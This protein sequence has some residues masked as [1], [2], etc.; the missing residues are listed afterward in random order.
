MSANI[1]NAQIQKENPAEKLQ[2]RKTA[3]ENK[4]N[5]KQDETLKKI[6]AK[7]AQARKAGKSTENLEKKRAEVLARISAKEKELNSRVDN[8][9]AKIKK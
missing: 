2:A 4:L 3:V 9:K 6:D 8:K 7:I 5:Q 1:A